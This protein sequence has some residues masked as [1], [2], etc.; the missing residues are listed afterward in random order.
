MVSRVSRKGYAG[1]VALVGKV[2]HKSIQIL[3]KTE[4]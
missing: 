2:I 3:L 1:C 4:V